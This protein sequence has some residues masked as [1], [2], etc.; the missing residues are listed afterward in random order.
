VA[1]RSPSTPALGASW[2]TWGR[3]MGHFMKLSLVECLDGGMTF[4]MIT[5]T[6]KY[7]TL[8]LSETWSLSEL[9]EL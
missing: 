7:M 8:Y 1:R 9:H 6:Y 2:E 4:C 3:K 5:V